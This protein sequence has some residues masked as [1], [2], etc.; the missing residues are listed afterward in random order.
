MLCRIKPDKGGGVLSQAMAASNEFY[1]TTAQIIPVLLPLFAVQNPGALTARISR[2]QSAT[3][4]L[5]GLV[6]TVVALVIDESAALAGL[7]GV[8]RDWF[9]LVI[10]VAL[11]VS[12]QTVVGPYVNANRQTLYSEAK[13]DQ[14]YRGLRSNRVTTY[15]ALTLSYGAQYAALIATAAVYMFWTSRL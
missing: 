10:I 11:G 6:A 9:P 5:F 7:L 15:F 2:K 13:S 4:E 1:A 14:D 8:E 12:V 3:D